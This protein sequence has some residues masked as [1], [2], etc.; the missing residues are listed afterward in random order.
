MERS[1]GG[2][3]VVA[4]S[5]VGEGPMSFILGMAESVNGSIDSR[6]S[7]G[8]SSASAKSGSVTHGGLCN[9]V[10]D[11]RCSLPACMMPSLPRAVMGVVDKGKTE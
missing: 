4:D 7:A 6:T 5:F 3:E 11:S 10:E 1:N 9:G 8:G 2:E